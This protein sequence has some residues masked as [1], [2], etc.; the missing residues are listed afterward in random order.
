[1]DT[2][3]TQFANQILLFAKNNKNGLFPIFSNS[4]NQQIIP[5]NFLLSYLKPRFNGFLIKKEN[6]FPEDNFQELSPF[7]KNNTIIFINEI[8]NSFHYTDVF[9][10][11]K[12][13]IVVA[14]FEC[15]CS[16]QNPFND[17]LNRY[18]RI[19]YI[20]I[21]DLKNHI[22]SMLYTQHINDQYQYQCIDYNK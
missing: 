2:A 3:L 19:S 4:F 9:S 5:V 14:G 10:L 16:E 15:Y 7:L 21:A 17:F 22:I 13:H 1:M 12:N 18:Q 6:H 11:A 20:P 8:S